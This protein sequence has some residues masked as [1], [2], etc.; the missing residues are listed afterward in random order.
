MNVARISKEI[1]PHI[2]STLF[3]YIEIITDEKRTHHMGYKFSKLDD[4]IGLFV[5]TRNFEL[6]SAELFFRKLE[7][8]LAKC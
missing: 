6:L 4:F 7:R 1:Q 3:I 8:C 2:L 5:I